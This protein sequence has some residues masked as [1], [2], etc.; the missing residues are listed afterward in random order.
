MNRSARSSTTLNALLLCKQGRRDQQP[1]GGH[2]ERSEPLEALA[3]R[4]SAR[5]LRVGTLKY[6]EAVKLPKLQHFQRQNVAFGNVER[7]Q[8]VCL[9]HAQ[10]L[11]QLQHFV[12]DTSSF[13]PSF[14]E[15]LIINLHTFARVAST[16]LHKGTLKM[17]D[18]DSLN[19]ST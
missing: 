19:V 4:Q 6:G 8:L 12:S 1:P 7:D 13:L 10:S 9:L 3:R 17:R 14:N 18:L 11:K 16:L 2:F 5:Q 15:S